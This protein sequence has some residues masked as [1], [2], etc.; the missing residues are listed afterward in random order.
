MNCSTVVIEQKFALLLVQFRY[1][2][3]GRLIKRIDGSEHGQ[4]EFMVSFF[5]TH[6]VAFFNYGVNRVNHP[7][8]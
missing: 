2:G 8:Q 4:Q 7:H 3:L 1:N 5:K 6:E